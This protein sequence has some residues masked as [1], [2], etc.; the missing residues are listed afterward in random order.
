MTQPHDPRTTELLQYSLDQNTGDTITLEQFLAPLETRA[1]GFLLV[2]L[3]LPNFIPIPIGIGGVS[4]TILVLVGAQML[5]GMDRPWLPRFARNH[6][7]GRTSIEH[8]VAR[9]KPI[10]G[11][12]E[13]V[14]RPRFE[15]ITRKPCSHVS[16]FLL[17]VLGVLLA[18]PI[19]FT[20]YPFGFLMLLF[21]VAL[22][23]R[24]GILL[25]VVWTATAASVVMLASLSNAMVSIAKHFFS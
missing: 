6:G 18:L 12:L 15:Q 13:R 16:G 17:I 25:A 21:G 11:W 20:N 23:E 5:Y 10:F 2:L 9:M 22:I 24:D 3:S 7:F 19:P 14:C 8:F 1:Y 4:G